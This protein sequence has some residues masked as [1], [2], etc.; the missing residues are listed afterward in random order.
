MRAT[1]LSHGARLLLAALLLIPANLSASPLALAEDPTPVLPGI[2]IHGDAGFGFP[3]S[4]VRSGSGTVDDPYVISGWTVANA[5]HGVSLVG[6]RA[7]VVLRDLRIV[8]AGASLTEPAVCRSLSPDCDGPAGVLLDDARNV[9]VENVRV[10]I[11]TFGVRLH[12]AEDVTLTDLRLTETHP[13]TGGS[14]LLH[15]V[16]IELSR[17]V[18]LSGLGT[19]G[20]A[21]PFR[22]VRSEDV[23]V[24][25]LRATGAVTSFVVA[26]E[27]VTVTGNTFQ[28]HGL[29]LAGHVKGLTV[30]ANAFT[31]SPTALR[32][33]GGSTDAV[34]GALV[35]GNTFTG[36]GA[37]WAA[38]DL[39][40]AQDV[41]VHGNRFERTAAAISLTE[42]SQVRVDGNHVEGT[43]GITPG[44]RIAAAG[45]VLAH[46]NAFLAIGTAVALA[47]S[48]DAAGNWWGAAD[49]PSGD[50]AGSGT[51]VHVAGGAAFA[52]WLEAAPTLVRS[53]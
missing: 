24:E 52:P 3:Q 32:R 39:H 18:T 34:T 6:T 26:G 36:I 31:D 42:A 46:G 12:R 7:H 15:G 4:G 1:T 29:A 30:S 25:G 20:A 38:L 22:V 37:G 27:R 53:C 44:V 45:P 28:G 23:R 33:M 11:A 49:G 9:R 43:N 40:R 16:S 51:R 41:R 17:R 8:W 35:C 21:Y 14:S 2:V 13:L 48:V 47:G 5:R 10:D 19:D 50:G